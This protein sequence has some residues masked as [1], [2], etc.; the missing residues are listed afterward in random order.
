MKEIN[1][2][3]LIP[4]PEG[5]EVTV[6]ARV[7]TVK[8]KRG[9]LTRC[10]KHLCIDIYVLKESNEIKVN[11]DLTK[12]P[13]NLLSPKIYEPRLLQ[14]ECMESCKNSINNREYHNFTGKA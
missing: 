7:V 5:C 3:Q 12:Y 1:S 14:V 13:R 6:K 8:G 9:T 4:I 11:K 10:F 2:F